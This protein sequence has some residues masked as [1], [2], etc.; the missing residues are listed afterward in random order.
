MQEPKIPETERAM[1]SAPAGEGGKRLRGFVHGFGLPEALMVLGV[2]LIA[3]FASLWI[4]RGREPV[5]VP[6]AVQP[7]PFPTA[8]RPTA[9]ATP[10][11]TATSVPGTP[12][13]VVL[14]TI[15][16]APTPAVPVPATTAPTR[17]V[18]PSI[19]LDAPVVEVGWRVVERDGQITTEWEVA[20]NAAGFHKGSAYPGNVGNTVL[21]GH[22]NIRGKVFR[23]LVNVNPGDLII[24]YADDRAY[25]YRVESKQILPEK[26]ASEAQQR[27]N[28]E[29][30]GYF[31]DERLTLVTCWPYTSNTHRVVVIARPVPPPAEVK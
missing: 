14:P 25:S 28:A 21:S 19:H 9:T 3:T 13:K 20:D 29:F 2:V 22:H 4:Q 5:G 23:Y 10:P 15:P 16:P 31:P 12:T 18:I 27:K 24:L 7:T 1:G 17:I 30:I 26:Y 8:P 11:P 6:A